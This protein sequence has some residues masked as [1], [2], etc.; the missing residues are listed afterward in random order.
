MK[1]KSIKMVH[2]NDSNG[3]LEENGDERGESKFSD[4]TPERQ[5]RSMNKRPNAIKHVCY[6]GK[7]YI[8]SIE[9]LYRGS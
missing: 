2:V 7:E 5:R 1:A 3:V 8:Y 4:Y 9:L 6:C